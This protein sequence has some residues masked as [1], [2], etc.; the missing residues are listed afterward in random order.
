MG[1]DIEA[2]LHEF[3]QYWQASEGGTITDDVNKWY[4]EN[5]K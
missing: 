2:G 4:D 3:A 5:K 1:G